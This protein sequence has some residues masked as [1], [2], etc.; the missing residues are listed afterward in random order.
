MQP[1]GF[2]KRAGVAALS[3]TGLVLASPVLASPIA[4][5]A[6][7]SLS[8]AAPYAITL[9]AA[10]FALVS[11]LLA[12]KWRREADAARADSGERLG[13]M[14]AALDEFETL[15]AGMPEVTIIWRDTGIEP[16]VLGPVS[17]LLPG[18]TRPQAVLEFR[19][20]LDPEAARELAARLT[21]L[22]I[23]GRMF[24]TSV[25]ARDGRIVRATG[26]LVGGTAVV[27][28]RSSGA[29]IEPPL[30]GDAL[31]RL[32]SPAEA[33][34]VLAS[35]TIPAWLRDK[36]G[37]LIYANAA[38][39]HFTRTLGLKGE[40]GTAP[41]IFDAVTREK[42][43]KALEDAAD[44]IAFTEPHPAAGGLDLVLFP[45]S[46]GSAGY[47]YPPVTRAKPAEAETGQPDLGH[48]TTVIDALATPIA[49]FDKR[50]QLTHYNTAYA[51]FWGLDIAWLNTAPDE[52]AI[53][54]RLRTQ[55][56][57]PAE[58]D[59]RDWRARHLMSYAL[60]SPRETPWYLPDGRCA[61]VI[62]AP[63]TGTG[64]VIY[65]FEDMTERLEL[66]TRHNALIHVQRETLNALSE[67]V[68]VF[69]TNGRLRLHNP[70]LALLW[71]L[72]MAS[73]GNHP[74]I[75]DMA[76]ACAQA[77]PEDGARIWAD[78][79]QRVV[80]L[81]PNRMDTKGRINRADG[82]LLDY[83]VVRLPDGQT[84][85]TFVDV[86]ESANYERVLR[87]RNE[88]LIAAD[89]LK[90]TF[91]QNVSYELRSPLTNIIGFADLLAND[92]GPL[93]DKQ[94]SYTDYIRASSA[95]L[96]LLI[97]NIL[98]L[99]TVDAGIAQLHPEQLDIAQLIEKARAGLSAAFAGTDAAVDITVEIE[100]GL[101]VL[102]ADG[103][104]IVQVLYNLLSNAARF[105]DPGSEVRVRVSARGPD[106]IAFA[107]EDDGAGIPEDMR[108]A[109]FQRFE[110]QSVEGRQRG[111]GLG[112]AIV[113][114]FVNLHGGTVLIESREP[115]G[116]RVTV[117]VP[118]NAA[119]AL[120]AG[121]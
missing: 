63:A 99:A 61:N 97:D 37:L 110:G 118:A 81:D 117:I 98:D 105:S 78:L 100:D 40:R 2:R 34:A 101:P 10:G 103:T 18:E 87:E 72:P 120:N 6:A 42:H 90:D 25:T 79:K 80:D 107:V 115:R 89:R 68:A 121:E 71:S 85:M 94:R 15:L 59:Y 9:G 86:S 102:V 64:G 67:G 27:R 76:R 73:L 108:S 51:R 95:N 52:R 111:A 114:T 57:L 91:V 36:D 53:L 12:L 1:A 93:N 24:E 88:A 39:L 60:T 43:L 56:M 4:P 13:A 84:M 48:L 14:R 32:P 112:L 11:A 22:R 46:G 16:S 44:T 92:S 65:V 41:D 50:R 69:G 3:A 26:R 7:T 70:R 113:K 116:T 74:H 30:R 49:V 38:Y 31:A 83:A 54:D 77:F 19:T 96:G 109:M 29:S 82:R 62:A 21:D 17:A 45:L 75:D 47:C 119:L 55:G 5:L 104:R 66:E 33:Q 8:A 58:T 106:H 20:W 23:E 35:L 28:L